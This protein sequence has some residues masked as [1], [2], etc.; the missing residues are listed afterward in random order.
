VPS[1]KAS[2][3]DYPGGMPPLA[4]PVSRLLAHWE[5]TSLLATKLAETTS[6]SLRDYASNTKPFL[7]RY[8][9]GGG[10]QT[11]IGDSLDKYKRLC[12]L[13]SGVG[14]DRSAVLL[15]SLA[16]GRRKSNNRSQESG[17][18][19]QKKHVRCESSVVRRG[20]SE[21]ATV[22]RRTARAIPWSFRSHATSEEAN[23]ERCQPC[24]RARGFEI[25]WSSQAFQ[26]IFVAASTAKK[27]RNNEGTAEE[28][29]AKTRFE[30]II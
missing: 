5:V 21:R 17:V 14:P 22:A 28:F 27:K 12:I 6:R 9:S 25:D 15:R 16:C 7:S 2:R 13:Q 8:A 10:S 4:I 20:P 29:Y 18:W 30:A 3:K 1:V 24:R 19:S 26:S 11:F 23:F